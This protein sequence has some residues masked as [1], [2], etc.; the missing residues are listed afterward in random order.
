LPGSDPVL[1][2]PEA[3]DWL[4]SEGFPVPAR[5]F[6]Q[7]AADAA[8]AASAMGTPVAMKVVA[9][10]VVHKTDIGGVVL[11]V[12]DE[13]GVRDAFADLSQRATGLGFRGVLV[14]PMVR[15]AVELLVGVSRDAQFGPI[16]AVGLG[17]TAAEALHDVALRVA[18]I[19][20][21][22]AR[23]MLDELRAA[24]L[25]GAFRGRPA[26]DSGALAEFVAR[27]SQLPFR[28]PDLA[29]LDVNPLFALESG[30]VIGDVRAVRVRTRE[31]VG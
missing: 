24:P 28:Y 6:A 25:L 9:S 3:M 16:I 12:R 19:D 27:V 23:G 4:E 20:E 22:E 31:S 26:R 8:V 14:V 29:E 30:V 1:L 10:G 7:T 21:A 13:A 11:D 2:E 15:D 5:R 17:G 18:P